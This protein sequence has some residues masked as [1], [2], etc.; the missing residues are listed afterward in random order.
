[1]FNIK[2]LEEIYGTYYNTFYIF[3]KILIF[4]FLLSH[5]KYYEYIFS[6]NK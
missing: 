2:Y 3:Y 5:I 1:M 4:F 6:I